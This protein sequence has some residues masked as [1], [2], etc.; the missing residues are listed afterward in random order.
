MNE[1]F[2]IGVDEFYCF[3]F[4]RCASL[5]RWNRVLVVVVVVGISLGVR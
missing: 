5:V 4:L 2:L 3:F 1:W